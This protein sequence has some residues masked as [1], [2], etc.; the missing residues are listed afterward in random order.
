M[1]FQRRPSVVARCFS[2]TELDVTGISSSD[3]FTHNQFYL[4]SNYSP[5]NQRYSNPLILISPG[6][7]VTN[8]NSSIPSLATMVTSSAHSSI[9]SPLLTLSPTEGGEGHEEALKNFTLDLNGDMTG[10]AI[11][12]AMPPDVFLPSDATSLDW[13]RPR[14]NGMGYGNYY[15]NKEDL[16]QDLHA[17]SSMPEL[18]DVTFLVGEGRQPVCGVR[19]IL[20]ARSR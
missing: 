5:T 10:H 1:E 19:A 16:A 2:D 17:L 14:V 6:T 3:F 18:C 20:A 9:T 12:R 7:S 15:V 8:S 11:D 13:G 4:Q